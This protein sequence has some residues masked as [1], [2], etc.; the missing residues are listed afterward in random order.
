MEPGTLP[1]R[2]TAVALNETYVIN[3]NDFNVVPAGAG[4]PY[5]SAILHW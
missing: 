4:Y 1:P 3:V 2:F 5:N